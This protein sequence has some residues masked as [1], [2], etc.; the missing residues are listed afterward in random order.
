MGLDRIGHVRK[1]YAYLSATRKGYLDVF[2]KAD[3]SVLTQDRGASHGSIRDVF[4]HMMSAHRGWF[5]FV[6]QDK[7]A[8]E[9]R[10][11]PAKYL[12]ASY[13][14][15]MEAK[16]DAAL[17]E[18][19]RRLEPSD[20]AKLHADAKGREHSTEAILLHMIEEELQH[21][22]EI[23]CMLWQAGLDAPVVGYMQW[24]R[25]DA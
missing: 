5:E 11:D 8:E 16:I 9:E 2:D 18:A 20:L 4:V 10:L 23:N 3:W 19:T 17:R 7:A 22:G 21:R 14:R 13:L 15:S 25:G 6:L 1:L 24:V 12:D